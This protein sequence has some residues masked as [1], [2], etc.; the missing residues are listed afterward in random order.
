MRWAATHIY[1][2]YLELGIEM[3]EYNERILHAKTVTID[4][5]YSSVGSFNMDALS[6]IKMLELNIAM[7]SG[8]VAKQLERQFAEDLRHCVQIT[9][10]TLENRSI[11][12][13]LLHWSCYH[14]SRF[15]TWWFNQEHPNERMKDE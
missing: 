1:H 11:F 6:G 5:I 12:E 3:Y 9:K 15:M 7:I 2:K 4:G 13:K 14:I 10:H 8:N